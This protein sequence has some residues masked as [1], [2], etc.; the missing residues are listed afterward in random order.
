MFYI[1][2]D[3]SRCSFDTSLA[4]QPRSHT[5]SSIAM[6]CSFSFRRRKRMF[7]AGAVATGCVTRKPPSSRVSAFEKQG[8][9]HERYPACQVVEAAGAAK[10]LAHYESESSALRAARAPSQPVARRAD[11]ERAYDA[12]DYDIAARALLTF[13][14]LRPRACGVARRD[15]S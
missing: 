9:T 3:A 8:P 10:Q 1:D 14:R 15:E 2:S 7:V 12:R 6:E 13:G 4:A 5:P 11:R